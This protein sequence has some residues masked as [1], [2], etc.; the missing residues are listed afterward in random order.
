MKLLNQMIFKQDSGRTL[1]DYESAHSDPSL[2]TSKALSTSFLTPSARFIKS[3]L[4]H[5]MVAETR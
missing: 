1:F 5:A 4:L 2:P 3:R